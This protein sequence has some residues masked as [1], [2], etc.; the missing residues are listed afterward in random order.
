ML[1]F[2][3][4]GTGYFFGGAELFSSVG[5]P[6]QTQEALDQL[7]T[8]IPPSDESVAELPSARSEALEQPSSSSGVSITESE[9][10]RC[11]WLVEASEPSES[12]E[13]TLLRK[14]F[15]RVVQ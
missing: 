6:Q 9:L 8:L 3:P 12:E 14:S 15:L 7:S 5:P 13:T 1:A 4:E 10:K 11:P 2:S